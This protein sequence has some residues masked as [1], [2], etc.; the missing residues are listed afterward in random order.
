[1]DAPFPQCLVRHCA[2]CSVLFIY[3]KKYR[4]FVWVRNGWYSIHVCW[5]KQLLTDG[6]PPCSRPPCKWEKMR[7]RR[8]LILWEFP[9]LQ[10]LRWSI[11]LMTLQLHRNRILPM[12]WR[13][14]WR[15]IR[16]PEKMTACGRDFVVGWFWKL[17]MEQLLWWSARYLPEN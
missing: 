8:W 13:H 16:E 17:F 4:F 11:G 15:R 10:L 9:W 7:S 2:A 6:H 3:R 14:L 12:P 5:R 1:M